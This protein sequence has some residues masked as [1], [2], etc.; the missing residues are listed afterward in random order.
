[1]SQTDES[2]SSTNL[3]KENLSFILN[4]IDWMY[5]Y[6][7]LDIE[8][9]LEEQPWMLYFNIPKIECK[10]NMQ[11]F[12]LLLNIGEKTW[13]MVETEQVHQSCRVCRNVQI[14]DLRCEEQDLMPLIEVIVI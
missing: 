1:M 8:K 2:K 13:C 14:D 4:V 7:I 5:G 9:G 3:A 12:L 6:C 11:Q 10:T